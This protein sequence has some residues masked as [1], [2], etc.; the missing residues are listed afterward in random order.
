VQTETTTHSQVVLDVDRFK[1]VNDSLGHGMGDELL[2]SVSQRLRASLRP[3]D[4][5]A[6][7][8]GDEFVVLIEG[9]SGVEAATTAATRLLE[10]FQA[11]LNLDGR[12][13]FVS[14]SIGVACSNAGSVRGGDLLRNADIALYRAKAQGRARYVVFESAMA[15]PSVERLT[16]ETDLR[17]ALGRQ[18]LVLYFQPDIELETGHIAGFEA[19][20]RWQHPERGLIPPGDFIPIAEESGLIVPIGQWVLENACLQARAWSESF[21]TASHLVISVNLSGRQFQQ[22][23]IVDEIARVLHE[24]RIDPGRVKLEITESVVVEDAETTVSRLQALKQLGVRLAI[25]DFGTGYSS[26]SYLRRLPVDTI[27]IDRSFV[28]GLGT[29]DRHLSIVNAITSLAHALGMDV[30]AEGVETPEQLAC[31]RSVGCDRGQGYF[32]SRPLPGEAVGQLLVPQSITPAE[33]SLVAS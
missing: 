12:D 20:I 32:F 8:G 11:P 17:R 28:M 26:L 14:V 16:I 1:V 33:Q 4:T 30:T 7:F 31:L 22:A 5:V 29:D 2:A 23:N 10:Q 18:E 21:P 19:L 3:G 13:A 15:L 9:I 6:R 27:K 25:D 24:S